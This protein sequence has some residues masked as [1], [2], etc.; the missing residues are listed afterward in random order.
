M[1]YFKESE[2]CLALKLKSYE[3]SLKRQIKLNFSQIK[4]ALSFGIEKAIDN[5]ITI[6]D[7]LLV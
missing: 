4:E 7:E 1:W 6:S 5:N 2:K 3:A